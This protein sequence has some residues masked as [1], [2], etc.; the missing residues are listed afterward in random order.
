M[1]GEQSPILSLPE[2]VLLIAAADLAPDVR[3]RA[4]FQD[5]DYAITRPR[6]RT[7]S[8]VINAETAALLQEFRT[9]STIEDAV[10]RFARTRS[11]DP[12]T[13]LT[14]A[15]PALRQL[16]RDR[17]LVL[18]DSDEAQPIKASL[19]PR[20][21]VDGFEVVAIVQVLEDTEVYQVR[22]DG[23]VSALKLLRTSAG[24]GGADALAREQT[25]LAH[26]DG[27]V[28]AAVRASGSWQTRPYLA[29]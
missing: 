16:V 5:G 4:E 8:R 10:I 2:D 1:S 18:S 23:L 24:P 20:D 25:L 27:R 29:T 9:P 6:S 11:I 26:L 3:E 21:R 14:Q 19:A 7:P 17:V 15:F 12:E 28:N 13:T 22:R